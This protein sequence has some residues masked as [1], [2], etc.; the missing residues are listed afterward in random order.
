MWTFPSHPTDDDRAWTTVTAPVRGARVLTA[1][2]TFDA[3]AAAQLRREVRALLAH[4]TA[5]LVVDLA[6]VRDADPVVASDALRDVAHEAGDADVDL[7]VVRGP[8]LRLDDEELF[9]LYPTLDAALG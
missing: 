5:P 1:R 9:E 4:S 6:G 7:R 8:G 2:A 3:A